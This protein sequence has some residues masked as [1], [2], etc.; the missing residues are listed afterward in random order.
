MHLEQRDT[1]QYFLKTVPE[2]FA[3][4]SVQCQNEQSTVTCKSSLADNRQLD[5]GMAVTQS[6]EIALYSS[7]QNN[8]DTRDY[9]H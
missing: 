6:I 3:M 9:T 2:I 8:T 7:I 1:S 4:V 5:A